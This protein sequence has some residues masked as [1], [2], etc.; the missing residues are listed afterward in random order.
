MPTALSADLVGVEL[1]PTTVSWTP[2]DALLYAVG[3]GARPPDELDFLYEKQGPMVLP[4]VAVIPGMNV[5]GGETRSSTG[6]A[7]S[8]SSDEPCWLPAATATWPVPNSADPSPPH[9]E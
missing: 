2:A 5:M 7:P 1:E 9:E 4:T 8:G 3:V 6:G